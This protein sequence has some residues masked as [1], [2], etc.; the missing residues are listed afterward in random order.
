MFRI[1]QQMQDD[2][3]QKEIDHLLSKMADTE[4]ESKEYAEMADQLVKLHPLRENE[5]PKRVSRDTLITVTGNIVGI[6]L[7]VFHEQT[8]A[9]TSK[10]INFIK[11]PK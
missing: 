4:P 11:P 10:A 9:L 2:G 6:M 1:M 7:I 3:I 8:N 5:K